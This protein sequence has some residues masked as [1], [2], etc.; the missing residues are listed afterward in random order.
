MILNYK[1]R[2][3]LS[4]IYCYFTFESCPLDLNRVKEKQIKIQMF[5]GLKDKNGID[6]YEGDILANK[7]VDGREVYFHNGSFRLKDET[8]NQADQI[9]V[10]F[11]CSKLEIIGSIN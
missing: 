9:L 7:N 1:F 3:L 4:N 6:I 5:T 11:T 10:D 8:S 2:A